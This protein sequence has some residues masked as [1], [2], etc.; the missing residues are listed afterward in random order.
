MPRLLEEGLE[1][2]EMMGRMWQLLAP[3]LSS[4]TGAV[5]VFALAE[6]LSHLGRISFNSEE[7]VPRSPSQTPSNTL[8]SPSFA[9]I[10]L[11]DRCAL[12][13]GLPVEKGHRYPGQ[14]HPR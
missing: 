9:E 13:P 2:T 3:Q 14:G 6:T 12:A 11:R 1:N 5:E 8:F 4:F 7:E 10:S